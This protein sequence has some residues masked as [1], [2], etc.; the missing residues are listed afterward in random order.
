MADLRY[1]PKCK[2]LKDVVYFPTEKQER[3]GLSVEMQDRIIGHYQN[4]T[5]KNEKRISTELL[6]RNTSIKNDDRGDI[7]GVGEEID[8]DQG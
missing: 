4:N 7:P 8:E 3:L 1:V 6:S 2:E 5:E